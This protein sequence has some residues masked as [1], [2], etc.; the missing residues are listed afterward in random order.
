M[1]NLF[2]PGN[3]VPPNLETILRGT[4]EKLAGCT[5][6]QLFVEPSHGCAFIELEEEDSSLSVATSLDSREMS[7]RRIS[8]QVCYRS[9]FLNKYPF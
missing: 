1:T 9:D 3:Q 7:G 4:A 2:V 5:V 6:S 8:A